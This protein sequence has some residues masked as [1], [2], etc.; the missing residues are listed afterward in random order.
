MGS[1]FHRE[2]AD[3]RNF[4]DALNELP[5][6]SGVR[7]GA[8]EW[9]AELP[10]TE[11]AHTESCR[12][13]REQALEEFAETRNALAD[14]KTPQTGPWFTARVMAAIAAKEK[15][16]EVDGVW[17][18]VRRLAPRLVVVSALLLVV[19][20]A[21]AVQQ[22]RKDAA[23]TEMRSGDMVFDSAAVPTWHDD[24]MGTLYEVR[25]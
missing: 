2:N 9:L 8:E 7:L 18:S 23:T 12:A 25:P 11:A 14:M 17:I 3:C 24:G 16:E 21:W 1:L 6:K 15:E 20:G 19:G 13:C 5:V 10:V 22:T 4:R